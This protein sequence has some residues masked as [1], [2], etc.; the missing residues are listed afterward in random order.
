MLR[1]DEVAELYNRNFNEEMGRDNRGA[2]EGTED[3]LLFLFPRSE[4]EPVAMSR[5]GSGSFSNTRL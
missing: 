4:I 3:E 2:H 5:F 1:R